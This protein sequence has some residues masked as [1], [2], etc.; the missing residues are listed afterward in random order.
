MKSLL[1]LF[2]LITSQLAFDQKEV[3][4]SFKNDYPDVYHLS[5]ILFTPDGKNQT[6]VSNLE[7]AQVKTYNLPVGTTIYI[8]DYKQEAFAMQGND[9]RTTGKKPDYTVTAGRDAV[10]IVLSEFEKSRSKTK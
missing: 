3:Q 7:P 8:A 9:I 1:L 2:A 10:E 5:L 6:R 4:L